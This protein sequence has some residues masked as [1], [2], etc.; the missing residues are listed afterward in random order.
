MPLE[1]VQSVLDPVETPDKEYLY[2][3]NFGPQH[4]ATH[5]TLR[6]ILTLDGETIVKAVP[7][8]GYLHSGF[9]KLGEDLDFNQYVTVVDRMNYISPIANEIAWHNAVETL[10]GIELTP[11][12]KYLRT[13]IAEL[14]RISDHL[15]CVGACGLDLGALT[16][17]LYAF[18]TREKIYDIFETMSGQRFHPSYSRVGGLM[19]DVTDDWISKIRQFVK[20]F[21]KPHSELTRLLNRNR[22]FVD[23]TKDVGVLTKEEAINRSASGPVARAS[24]VVRDLRKNEPY[25]AY[26]ELADS[27]KVI[28][29]KD[30][31]CY[32]RYL[33]RMAEMEQ[34][35][36]IIAAAVENIP[37]GPVNVD[38]DEKQG[39]PDK[40]AVYRSI[41]GL[42][43][44]FEMIM[45]NRR[46]TAPVDE[47]YSAVEAPN[48]EL[49]F[50]IV[51]DGEGRAY[52]ARTRPPSFIH[53]SM[54]PHLIEG[55]QISDVPA[56][57][58]SLNIIAAELDR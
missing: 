36:K 52:R 25:L 45:T 12:C 34:S 37:T 11:R 19:L 6:L 23:R 4:P 26:G 39:L 38:V 54:F 53:F 20:D 21:P 17:F 44:H 5:T 46:W 35:M 57:L 27:F 49:G 51:G 56:V 18:N 50:Y 28:V 40:N 10:L 2:T 43:Q 1:A 47:V 48:G 22:I 31:D 7:D 42:I 3:L 14:A 8:I 32:T 16:A 58:G 29:G 9:E 13:I 24:G 41:E 15:L 33:V 55:H 30:G